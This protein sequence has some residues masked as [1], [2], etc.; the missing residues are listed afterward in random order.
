MAAAQVLKVQPEASASRNKS[1]MTT[2]LA[3]S[4]ALITVGAVFFVMAGAL[5]TGT[6]ADRSVPLMAPSLAHASVDHPAAN[7]TISI[8]SPSPDY[9]FAGP[10]DVALTWTTSVASSSG[11]SLAN[12]TENVSILNAYGEY[13]NRPSYSPLGISPV[14]ANESMTLTLL[15]IN[16]NLITQNVPIG[17]YTININATNSSGAV[18]ASASVTVGHSVQTIVSPTQGVV[19]PSGNVTVGYTYAQ[20][21]VQTAEVYVFQVASNGSMTQI[22]SA[23][24][25]N[26]LGFGTGSYVVSLTAGNYKAQISTFDGTVYSNSSVTFSVAPVSTPGQ[27]YLNSTSSYSNSTAPAG[28]ALN[29]FG[30]ILM[31]IGI[32]IGLIVGFALAAGMRPRSAEAN[33][34]KAWEPAPAGTTGGEGA[35]AHECSICHTNFPD[36]AALEEHKKTAHNM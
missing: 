14:A 26:P 35:G 3:V 31:I 27:V 4:V 36:D 25:L 6:G 17:L 2:L 7:V 11:I 8:T 20:V 23:S 30:T 34:P 29:T 12:L 24:V 22:F 1:R 15:D 13:L 9:Q 33:A 21:G 18:L 5:P 10:F 28:I 19:L 32:V 16:P